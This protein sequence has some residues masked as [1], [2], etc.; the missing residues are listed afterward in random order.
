MKKIGVPCCPG[1]KVYRVVADRRVKKVQ[2]CVVVGLWVSIK[3]EMNDIHIMV[4]ENGKFKLSR[5]VP[6]A[7]M[8]KSLFLTEEEAEAARKQFEEESKN[9]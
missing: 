5:S 4:E 8:G 2:K 9:K 3:P 6:F 1:D 7:E